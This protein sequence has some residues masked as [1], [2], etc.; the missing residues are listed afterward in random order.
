MKTKYLEPSKSRDREFI[1]DKEEL[2]KKI[3]AVYRIPNYII[4]K[5]IK[6]VVG[7]AIDEIS[8]NYEKQF[9]PDR[10]GTKTPIGL[11][12]SYTEKCGI[13]KKQYGSHR[14]ADLACP[15]KKRNSNRF[16]YNFSKTTKFKRIIK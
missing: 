6:K 5:K 9:F 10:W 1:K 3:L 15:V 11:I 8:K 4:N 13:C 2:I 14:R 12:P 7:R 16:E